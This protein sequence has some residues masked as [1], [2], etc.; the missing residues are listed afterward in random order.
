M[1]RNTDQALVTYHF[2]HPSLARVSHAVFTR[3]GGVSRGPFASLNVG[4]SVGDDRAAVAENHARI[5]SYLGLSADRV[6]TASQVH[7]NRIA[8]VM[9]DD[10]G[11]IFPNADGLVTNQPGVALMLRFADCQPI[12]LY[13][14]V[15]HALGLVHAGW[16]GVAQ[17]AVRRAVE[18]MR[19]AFGSRPEELIAG[20]GPAIGVCCYT[21]GHEVAAVMGYALPDWNE[22]LRPEGSD[23]WRLDLSAANAQQLAAAGVQQIEQA[24]LC[25]GCHHDEFFSHRADH[26]HT[27]RFAVVAFLQDRATVPQGAT[28]GRRVERTAPDAFAEITSLDPPGLPSFEELMGATSA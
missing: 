27:G 15:H 7:S 19:H 28:P 3:L 21:V 8:V 25:T 6:A 18:T 4:R 23:K 16:R 9:N 24:H 2:E 20:L 22:V 26:G 17:G 10:G 11:R 14:P 13:D 5:Y 12:L 1:K